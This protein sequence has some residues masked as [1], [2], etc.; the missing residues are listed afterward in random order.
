MPVSTRK[1]VLRP[2]RLAGTNIRFT[3]GSRMEREE[4]CSRVRS[5]GSRVVLRC[6]R[7][8]AWL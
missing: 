5:V 8:W 1:K 4:G 6:E 3:L 7:I 2:S